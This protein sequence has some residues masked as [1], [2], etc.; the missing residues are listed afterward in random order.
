[1]ANTAAAQAIDGIEQQTLPVEAVELRLSEIALR[2]EVE[3]VRIDLPPEHVE[4]LL[5]R[6][7]MPGCRLCP[8][9][10]SPS[11]D[12]IVMVDGSV[13]ALRREMAG[14]L[15]VRAAGRPAD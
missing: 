8:V 3:L 13:L 6:G 15:C 7:L 11:G 9:R 1:V 5:E 10:R 4:P 12:P 2:Q 14:C